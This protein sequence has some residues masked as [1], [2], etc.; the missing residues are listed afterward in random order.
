MFQEAECSSH[1]RPT[2]TVQTTWA[3]P[4]SMRWDISCENSNKMSHFYFQAVCGG[5]L[6]M[7]AGQLESPNFPEDYQPNKECIWRVRNCLGISG[8]RCQPILFWHLCHNWV[9]SNCCQRLRTDIPRQSFRVPEDFQVA[10]KF[11]SFEIENHD[12]CVYD[13]LE[14]RDGESSA[15]PLIGTFCGYKMPKDIKSTSNSLWIKFVSD[16]SVQKAGFSAS[17]MKVRSNEF[18][19]SFSK[20]RCQE[21]DECHG[22]DHGCEHECIN[23]LGGYSCSCRWG[24]I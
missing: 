12:N 15:A 5:D 10:L 6:D 1:T 20:P 7:E 22:P 2:F 21:Y 18:Y 3:S 8:L 16:G 4:L 23:T 11:Q 19:N 17:F 24:F 14:I 9:K 13:F